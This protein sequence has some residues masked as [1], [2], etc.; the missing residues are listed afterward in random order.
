MGR[1]VGE[2]DAAATPQSGSDARSAGEEEA[3]PTPYAA[4]WNLAETPT[5]ATGNLLITDREG[6]CRCTV[7]MIEGR[8]TEAVMTGR[9]IVRAPAMRV[10][11][12]HLRDEL[13]RDDDGARYAGEIHLI[14]QELERHK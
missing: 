13:R 12:E 3:R 11:L 1:E 14:N 2:P 10:L 9:L 4:P 5:R 7:K 8:E 6:V